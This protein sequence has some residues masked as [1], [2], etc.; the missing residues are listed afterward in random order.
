MAAVILTQK[1]T[2][3]LS[4]RPGH[5]H[6]SRASSHTDMRTRKFSILESLGFGSGLRCSFLLPMMA[7][8]E[9]YY[10]YHATHRLERPL[11]LVGFVNRVTRAVAHCLSATTGLPLGIVDELVEHHAGAS[12]YQLLEKHGLGALRDAEERELSKLLRADAPM[13]VALG[14]GALVRPDSLNALLTQ[15]DLVYLYLPSETACRQ[16]VQQSIRQRASLW[17]ELGT[18]EGDDLEGL[19][20]IFERRRFLY[21]L[22][23][24]RIDVS[25]Q[26][27]AATAA[28]LRERLPS[29]S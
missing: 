12:V 8:M 3:L 24:T 4:Q 5:G 16:A 10:D 22:A 1:P 29:S 17:A 28:L 23:Q 27:V 14:E 9:G 15:T 19:R 18:R 7:S 26:S 13:I 21:E 2:G 11:A 20:A 6:E 25:D